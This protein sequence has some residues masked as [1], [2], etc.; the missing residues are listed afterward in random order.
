M[1][2][3]IFGDFLQVLCFPH[4]HI[5]GCIVGK[6]S[7]IP[8]AI[9]SLCWSFSLQKLH[10]FMESSS[11]VLEITSRAFG[12]ISF[13]NVVACACI[14]KLFPFYN[15]F[16]VSCLILRSLVH[17]YLTFVHDE[18]Y[19]FSYILHVNICFLSIIDWKRTVSLSICVFFFIPFWKIHGCSCMVYFWVLS[20]TGLHVCFWASTAQCL[21]LL[22]LCGIIW[23]QVLWYFQ[24][25]FL[26]RTSLAT[27]DLLCF[28]LNFKII[29]FSNSLKNVIGFDTIYF[30]IAFKN[31]NFITFLKWVC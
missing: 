10:D 28:H 27:W 13:Q 24:N 1:D 20:S 21:L 12:V 11:P 17:L 9:S 8:G 3:W 15:N 18:K 26:L 31:S 19:G 16:K 4:V 23:D 6:D 5:L 2:N 29:F 7:L 25:F 22:W 14:L 30:I